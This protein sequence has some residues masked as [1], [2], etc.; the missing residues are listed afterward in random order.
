MYFIFVKVP[1]EEREIGPNLELLQGI[2][3]LERERVDREI[4]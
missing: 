4:G 2:S 1:R 3:Y